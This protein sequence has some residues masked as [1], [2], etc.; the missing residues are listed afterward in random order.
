MGVVTERPPSIDLTTRSGLVVRI[1][2]A[3]QVDES[4]LRAGFRHLSDESRYARFF[5]AV[6]EL[7]GSLLRSLT[8][9]DGH[10]RFAFAVFDP[11][12]PSELPVADATGTIDGFGVGVARFIRSDAD[13]DADGTVA[14]LSIAVI[15]DYHGRGVGHLM[16]TG[17]LV[18]A[19]HHGVERLQAFVLTANV[20]MVHLLQSFGADELHP[21]HRDPAVR[22]FEF[23]LDSGRC[24][25]SLDPEIVAAF[26]RIA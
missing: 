5:T 3:R 14:E 4:S 24:L 2:Q 17:L 12:I 21:A 19:Q 23:A 18:A 20:A 15:D 6:P 13:A 25:E 16:L 9:L 10:R 26:A 1:R 11:A 22:A 7:E 8:D